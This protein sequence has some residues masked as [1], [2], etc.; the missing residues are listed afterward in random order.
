[1]NTKSI[2]CN[3]GN[4]CASGIQQ[5]GNLW[6]LFNVISN[7]ST[8]TLKPKS[9]FENVLSIPQPTSLSGGKRTVQI[10][11]EQLEGCLTPFLKLK[12]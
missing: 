1:M 12:D 9:W 8:Q 7:S 4:Q 5:L 3:T 6:G 10:N 11:T 2:S